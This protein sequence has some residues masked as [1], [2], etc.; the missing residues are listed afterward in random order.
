MLDFLKEQGYDIVSIKGVGTYLKNNDLNSS[1]VFVILEAIKRANFILEK[2]L[3]K[4]HEI[5]LL[6]EGNTKYFI[7]N[8]IINPT[9]EIGYSDNYYD[10]Q[11]NYILFS[12]NSW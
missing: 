6:L 5:Y 2:H 7:N 4:Y 10:N 3:H 12:K 11:E 8:E 1:D 9:I